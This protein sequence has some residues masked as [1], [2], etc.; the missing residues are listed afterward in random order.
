MAGD[1]K[2]DVA[3]SFLADDEPLAVEIA[4]RIRDRVGVFIYSESQKGLI[5]NMESI[6][7]VR[8]SGKTLG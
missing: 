6:S 5:G 8:F 7:S 4:D 2:Y 1:Y 3:F